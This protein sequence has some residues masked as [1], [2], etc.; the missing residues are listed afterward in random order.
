MERSQD[1]RTQV[2]CWDQEPV[3]ADDKECPHNTDV[4]ERPWQSCTLL[5]EAL[6]CN[7]FRKAGL[8]TV[9]AAFDLEPPSDSSVLVP[10]CGT[11]RP[12]G[13]FRALRLCEGAWLHSAG[14][15][16][17]GHVGSGSTLGEDAS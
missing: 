14:K 13:V 17:R 2:V 8:R 11:P 1:F 5:K 6:H 16:A 10:L 12:P 15:A 4:N 7:H 3:G 9:P